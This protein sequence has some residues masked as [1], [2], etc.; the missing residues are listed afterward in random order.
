M[1][2]L[3]FSNIEELI[4]HDR[5]AQKLL[6]IDFF[7]HFE[8]WRIAKRFPMLKTLGKQAV[9][10]VLNQLNDQ[11]VFALETYFGQKIIVEKL[12][13][14]VVK[15]LKIPLIEKEICDALCVVD[16]FNYFGTWRDDRYLYITFWR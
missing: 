7:N 15:N 8:Q 2:Q 6:P 9:L 14:S 10:D 3:S 13:Y 11:N 16:G 5:D 12:S 1:L 4:F